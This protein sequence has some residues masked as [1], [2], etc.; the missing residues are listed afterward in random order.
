MTKLDAYFE[1]SDTP[2]PWSP[3]AYAM[4][5]VYELKPDVDFEEVRFAINEVGVYWFI[6]KKYVEGTNE[7][8]TVTPSTITHG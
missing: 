1:R 5:S 7:S 8:A 2:S 4:R 3:V 6:P